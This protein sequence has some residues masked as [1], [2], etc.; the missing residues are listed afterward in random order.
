MTG[1][2]SWPDARSV[3]A[4][5]WSRV[6][7]SG[8]C[9]LWM[10]ARSSG[11]YGAM[12]SRALGGQESAH[13]V[14]YML[15][16]GEVPRSLFVLHRCDVKLC[17]RPDHLFLGT[18]AENSADMVAKGRSTFGE[19]H[20]KAKLDWPTVNAIR[21][22]SDRGSLA[23]L[24]AEHGVN[25]TTIA[26]VIHGESWRPEGT[27]PPPAGVCEG[28]NG[29]CSQPATWRYRN[30]VTR[31]QLDLCADHTEGVFMT[32]GPDFIAPIPPV[33]VAGGRPPFDSKDGA[34]SAADAR[35]RSVSERPPSAP[36]GGAA[37]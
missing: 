13:R 22:Q 26:R 19:R 7:R 6:D 34:E 30:Q 31:V 11:G 27:L 1:L 23:G 33:Q 9:W 29:H 28:G 2:G 14:S 16:Y 37:A 10:G 20:P 15:A 17:V 3:E 8:E 32:W 21:S 18:A 12:N 25:P 36:K 5:F 24:A 4:F 35:P